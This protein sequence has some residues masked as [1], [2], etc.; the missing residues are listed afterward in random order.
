MEWRVG[1]TAFKA[2]GHRTPDPLFVKLTAA[3]TTSGEKGL[4]SKFIS[5]AAFEARSRSFAPSPA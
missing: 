5:K 2:R 3:A 1:D 4:R